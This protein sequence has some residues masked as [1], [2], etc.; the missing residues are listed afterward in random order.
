MEIGQGR[1][2]TLHG[3]F[4]EQ[5][6]RAPEAVAVRFAGRDLTYGELDA[7]A[8]R[9]ARH[10]AANGLAPGGL[11]AVALGRGAEVFV[12]L[13]AVLKAGG[14]YVPLEPGAP[15]PLLRHVLADAAPAVVVTEEAHRVRLTDAS[16]RAVVCVDSAA[17]AVA[18]LSA[19][20]PRVPVGPA[21]L[22]CVFFTSGSTALPKGALIEHR[23]L[24]AAYEGWRKVYAL[25]AAD[26]ILQTASLE[27]DVFTA[28]WVRALC[29]GAA[30]VVAPR[31]LTLDRTADI[32]ELPALVA[33]EGVTV[34]ELNASTARRLHGHLGT[35]GGGAAFAGVRLLT[36]GAE[37][38]FLDEQS[39]LH[40]L[41]GG[42]VRVLNVYGLAEASVDSTYFDA[43]GVAEDGRGTCLV[44]VP[45]PGSRVYVLRPDGGR[46]PR[47]A[48]GEIAVAGA[49]LGRGYL[50]RPR[51]E[52]GRFRSAGFDPDGRILLTGDV[53]RI[54]EDGVLEFL[55][56]AAG[57]LGSTGEESGRAQAA[58]TVA[59]VAAAAR[60]EGVLRSHPGVQ[61][62]AVAE[63][64]VEPGR[65]AVVGYAVA[66]PDA[67]ALDPWSLSSHLAEHLPAGE[68]PAAVVPLPAL[69]RTRAGKLDRGALPLPAPRHYTGPRSGKG[70]RGSAKSGG[71][72]GAGQDTDR[73][74]GCIWALPT[75]IVA[76]VAWVLT[77]TLFP[78]STDTSLV[79]SPYDGYFT[80]LYVCECVAFGAGVTFLLFGPQ[81]IARF[82]RPLGLSVAANLSVFWLLAAWWPQDNLY[83]ISSP[84]DWPR[85]AV[86]VYVFNVALMVAALVLV[87]FLAWRP[88]TERA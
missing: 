73:P 66:A 76:Y 35:A 85:Q 28:D 21:D 6:Q 58:G 54:R 8:N 3:R 44:G 50:K 47:G 16:G 1:A 42:G 69:P 78:R 49:G 75:L 56:R 55:G 19:D 34:L 87:R 4:E 38:W 59:R 18:A 32:A 51:E 62:C 9:L 65:R 64:E 10:L 84:S 22:A 39:A 82:K 14:A 88:P 57:V 15:D 11:A 37:K 31:N 24:L 79:P 43:E 83:R 86:L 26:R 46:A 52:A 27:F 29:T 12:A 13:L 74:P 30:L 33:A 81:V 70:G 20:P 67:A 17:E 53:G 2:G 72:A 80:W 36:V 7:R 63:V 45:F 61:E 41:L 5:A 25:T 48:V 23:H 40:R 60:T 71:L 68:A 77:D